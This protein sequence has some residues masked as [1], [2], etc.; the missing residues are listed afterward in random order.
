[1]S[2]CVPINA[3][4]SIFTYSTGILSDYHFVHVMTT[5]R[6]NPPEAVHG[7]KNGD[8]PVVRQMGRDR[9]TEKGE[10]AND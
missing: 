2:I 5:S 8:L 9:M 10:R 3:S 6:E 1:M 7:R 4:V